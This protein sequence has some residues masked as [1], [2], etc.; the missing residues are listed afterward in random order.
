MSNINEIIVKHYE[1]G[2]LQD[3]LELG[4]PAKGGAIKIY[5]NFNNEEEFEAKMIKALALREKGKKL[6][7]E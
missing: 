5:G 2:K 1:E 4:S 3:S 6:I 7:M